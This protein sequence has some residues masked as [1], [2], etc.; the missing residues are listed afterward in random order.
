MYE[1]INCKTEEEVKELS[2][3]FYDIFNNNYLDV[4]ISMYNENKE[5]LI[6]VKDNNKIIAGLYADYSKDNKIVNLSIIGVKEEYRN[7]HIGSLLIKRIETVSKKYNVE[8]II[9]DSEP[10][11]YDFYIKNNYKPILHTFIMSNM[12]YEEIKKLNK[13]NF[14]EYLHY[15][16][17]KDNYIN[18]TIEYF[19]D[20]PKKEYID[21]FKNINS[22][23]L[24]N[25]SYKFMKKL[26]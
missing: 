21:Y 6:Y 7:K 11:N 16:R 18:V 4:M 9:V 15:E 23:N 26:D 19:V 13:Y 20:Y 3:F 14:S 8:E 17:K 2:D 5:F 1:I 25:A 10:Y 22:S 24:S 12:N